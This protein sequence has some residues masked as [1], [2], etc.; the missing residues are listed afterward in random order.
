M[1]IR[2]VIRFVE[3][4]PCFMVLSIVFVV[5]SELAHGI[6]VGKYFWFYLSMGVMAVWSIISLAIHAKSV[7]FS[8]NDVLILL[9]G[10]ITLPISYWV[11]GSDVSSKHILLI[12]IIILYFYFKIAFQMN[13]SAHYWLPVFLMITGF[14]EAVWGLRQ[15]Y[16][17]SFSHHS[18]FKL[19][20]SFFNPGLYAGYL[21]VVAPM[22]FYYL[23]FEDLPQWTQGKH[24]G[25]NIRQIFVDF[26]KTLCDLCGKKFFRYLRWGIALLTFV[27]IL[28]VLPASMS[29]AAWLGGIGGCGVVLFLIRSMFHGVSRKN[30]FWFAAVA[31]V[32]II[33]CVGMYYLK[34]DSA[35]G[36]AL[37]WKMSLQ[38]V[39]KNPFGA[40]LGN[41]SGAYGEV[42]S[43]Y[44]ASGKGT[45]TEELVAGNPDYGFNEYLQIAVEGG[46]ISL[47]LFLVIVVVALRSL[48]VS[49]EWGMAGAMVSLL[50][51]AFFSYPFSVLPFLIV[52]VF[53][54]AMAGSTQMTQITQICADKTKKSEFIRQ[55]CV[56]C[57][58]LCCMIATACCLYKVYPAYGAYKKWNKDRILYTAGLYRDVV[59]SYEDLYPMLNDQ[60]QFLFEYAQSLS[61]TEQSAKSNEV[62]KRA[63]RISCDPMLYNIMG[64]N[65]QALKE[66][67]QAEVCF[68]KAS[69][70]VPH[71]IYPFYLL[72]LLYH[73]MGLQDRVNEMAELVQTKEPKVIS[74]AV[75]EMRMEVRKLTMHN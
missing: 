37:M 16:G 15:L 63:M 35:D 3:L 18:L 56:I 21:A 43:A 65:Y 38:A 8:C 7:R 45:E 25:H 47:V 24:K 6:V 51:F 48:I 62:L 61:K 2:R 68:F 20:G 67:E 10:L 69:H 71:R 49:R 46:V 36:R 29:R 42:Q 28:V 31:V 59:E 17:Y 41:F 11:N 14:V 54:L 52:F 13:K 30:I 23:I 32:F 40:G 74:T 39:I 44:F 64:K 4:I 70:I 9:F 33:C 58:P 60:L 26:V 75:R 5:N 57:V 34:K 19:T 72:A 22:A 66:Y 73:E 12:L 27:S 1:I 55:I 53:L 50:V